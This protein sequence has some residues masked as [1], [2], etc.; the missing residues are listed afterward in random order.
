MPKKYLQEINM[1]KEKQN[2]KLREKPLTEKNG[3]EQKSKKSSGV[4]AFKKK[5]NNHKKPKKPNAASEAIEKNETFE[6]AE[7]V[8][9]EKRENKGAMNAAAA[10]K[11]AA[12]GEAHGN[13]RNAEKGGAKGASK[14]N[15]G[16]KQSGAKVKN[17]SAKVKN[18]GAEVKNEGAK[19]KNEGARHSGSKSKSEGIKS[20]SEGIKGSS[21]GGA[22]AKNGSAPKIR[23]EKD[24]NATVRIIPLGGLHEIGKNMTAI[25]CG[26]DIIVVDCGLAFP[27]DEMPGVDLV[28]PDVTYLEAN[29]AKVRGIVLT[30]GHEDHIGAIPYVLRNI[31]APLYGTRLTLGIVRN[32]LKEFKLPVVPTLNCVE[33]GDTV[34]L[35]GMAVEFIHVNHSIADACALAIFT[36]LGTIVH[37]GDFKLDLTPIDGEIMDITRL[38]ELGREGVLLL[39]CEST[40]A[41]RP[42]YTPSERK[43]G[44]SLEYIFTTHKEQRIVIATFSSNVHRVQQ[45]IDTAARHGRK[46]AI[47]GRS[48]LNIVG[49]AVELGYMHVPEGVLIDISELNSYNPEQITLV[50][51]GSQGEPM[52]ALYRMAFGDHR[53]VRLDM[54]DVVVISSSPIP[55]NEKLV[56]RIV[57]ELCKCGVEVIRDSSVEV[58][59]SG[60]AC[61]EEI[62]LMLA[63]TKPQYYMP[64]HG[65]YK[66]LAANRSLAMSMGIESHN[67]FVSDIG[68]VLEIDA[69]GARING[70]VNAGRVLVDGYGVGDVGNIVLRDRLLL[71]QDGLIVIV[72]TVSSDGG[73]LLSGPDIVSRGFIYVRESED[74]MEEMRRIAQNSIE[75]CLNSRNRYDWYQ[76]KGKVKEDLTKFILAKTKRRPMIIPMIMNV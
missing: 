13:P 43:V 20:K 73:Y 66:H 11:K 17:E 29:A 6:M 2:E 60:H 27:D 50:T 55:G 76:I 24:P 70:T 36:P 48:M 69:F 44:A 49:A 10:D 23:I 22:K 25:E 5:K 67:I 28:I 18:E 65:E 74:F 3:A 72:A 63:L 1:A 57:N 38:G 71:S 40:N 19:V 45:I 47:T 58:H 54:N 32:K 35:G 68:N 51:T 15:K 59:V 75:S 4:P 37:T 34:R 33:A 56:G 46:V 39:M 16:A 64:V 62:K 53:D 61:Q 8:M 31:N 26:D 7:S 52:S 21:N 42:G 12:K 30:H 41:E 14:G 9:A